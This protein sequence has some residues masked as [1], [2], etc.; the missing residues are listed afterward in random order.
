MLYLRLLALG[1]DDPLMGRLK[2]VYRRVW[3]DTHL[4]FHGTAP[5]ILAIQAAGIETL[6]LKGAALA[7]AHYRNAGARPMADIDIAVPFGQVLPAVEALEHAGWRPVTRLTDDDLAFRHAMSLRGPAGHE[8]D[9]HWH[10]LF[11]SGRAAADAPFW[12]NTLPLTFRDI[13]VLQLTPALNLLHVIA[14]G[15]RPN[16]ETP[17]RWIADSLVLI[18]DE[19]AKIDW[20]LFCATANLLGI[21]RRTSLAFEYLADCHG[22]AIPAAVT[23]S[24]RAAR[25]RPAERLELIVMARRD[26][27]APAVLGRAMLVAAEFFRLARGRGLIGGLAMLPEFARYRLGIAAWPA[28]AHFVR[29]ALRSL[30]RRWRS[31]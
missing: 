11:E 12:Q 14:H 1:V 9:L 23:A 30:W 25:L 5:A 18:R 21:S 10:M 8:I 15:L 19:S 28:P 3:S 20:R 4:L 13:P 22:E 26:G 17:V 24:L 31:A 27:L 2:G 29:R 6:L 7:L 16:V